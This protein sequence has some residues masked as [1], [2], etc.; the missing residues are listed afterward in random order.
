MQF[1]AGFQFL[2]EKVNAKDENQHYKDNGDRQMIP[3][4]V[5]AT[6]VEVVIRGNEA[7]AYHC[8]HTD[9]HTPRRESSVSE[10]GSLRKILRGSRRCHKRR[11]LVCQFSELSVGEVPNKVPEQEHWL[12]A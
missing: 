12:T 4:K 7:L 2:E 3:R 6:D 1:G 9:E 8:R 5:G 10:M 11:V